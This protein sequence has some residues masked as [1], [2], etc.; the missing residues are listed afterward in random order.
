MER[1]PQ[2][3]LPVELMIDH[4][5]LDAQHNE[6]FWRIEALKESSLLAGEP[7]LDDVVAL[8][9][10]FTRHFATE[11]RLAQE[12]AI[13]FSIHAREHHQAARVLQKA[14]TDLGSGRLNLR[15]F[16]RYLEYWFE[17]HINE[18][19]KPLGY[20]LGTLEERR[21]GRRAGFGA[22]LTSS[23]AGLSA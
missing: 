2:G 13:E 9:S 6:I 19:D 4:G 12:A 7:P 21:S 23:I 18:Y 14:E 5:E 20:R 16:L 11:E 1:M 3:L 17:Q 15:T 10:C 22:P 8:V